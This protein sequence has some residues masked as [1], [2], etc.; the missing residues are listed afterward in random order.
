MSFQLNAALATFMTHNQ[1]ES[2]HTS[3][4]KAHAYITE[5]NIK[6]CVYTVHCTVYMQRLSFR[7]I[8]KGWCHHHSNG[9]A[10]LYAKKFQENRIKYML[11]VERKSESR[12][13]LL[14]AGRL[15]TAL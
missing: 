12:V 11:Y 6:M 8:A 9:I 15:A 14:C 1:M 10:M 3:Q 7:Y 5:R 13:A 2:T 4:A